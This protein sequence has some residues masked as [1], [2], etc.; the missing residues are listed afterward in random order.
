M[1]MKSAELQEKLIDYAVSVNWLAPKIKCN[2]M[3]KHLRSQLVRSASSPALNYAEALAA[4][5]KKD[6]IHKNKIVLK[7]LRESHVCLKIL[8]NAQL[9]P[10]I[11]LKSQILDQTNELISIFVATLKTAQKN[12]VSKQ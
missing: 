10:D 6:F 8:A 11:P 5:S 3:G 2:D 9:L 4:E 12:I 1:K 7:E